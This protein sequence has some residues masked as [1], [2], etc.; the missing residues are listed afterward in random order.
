MIPRFA[1]VEACRLRTN[2][3]VFLRKS[4]LGSLTADWDVIAANFARVA[5]QTSNKE[6]IR[7]IRPNSTFFNAIHEEFMGFTLEI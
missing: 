2:L 3:V 6:I 4:H 1:Q 5:L 7:E